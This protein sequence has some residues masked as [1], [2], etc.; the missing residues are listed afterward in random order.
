VDGPR[1]FDPHSFA[2]ARHGGIQ[3]GEM[4]RSLISAADTAASTVSPN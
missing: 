2:A 1:T 3:A 4:N